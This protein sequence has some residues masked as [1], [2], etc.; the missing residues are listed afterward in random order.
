MIPALSCLLAVLVFV[1]LGHTAAL[2][3]A[4]VLVALGIAGLVRRVP[5]AGAWTIGII[6]AGLL[7]RLS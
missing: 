5:F 7:V 4:A 2:A 6:A 3:I 1:W